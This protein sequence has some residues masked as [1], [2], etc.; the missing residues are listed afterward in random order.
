VTAL[1][2]NF[3]ENVFHSLLQILQQFD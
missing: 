2:G 1:H 3:Y